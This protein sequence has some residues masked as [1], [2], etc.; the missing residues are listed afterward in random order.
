MHASLMLAKRQRQPLISDVGDQA[1][2]T[3][4]YAGTSLSCEGG[5]IKG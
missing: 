5:A 3:D 1:A 4:A 2:L